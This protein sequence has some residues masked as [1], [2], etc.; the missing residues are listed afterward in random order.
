MFLFNLFLEYVT[1]YNV[2]S[3]ISLI[4]LHQE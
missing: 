4:R 2:S 1:Q 3:N